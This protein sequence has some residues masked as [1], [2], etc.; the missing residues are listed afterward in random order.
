MPRTRDP[1]THGDVDNDALTT[2][3]TTDRST[4]GLPSD[5]GVRG[6]QDAHLPPLEFDYSGGVMVHRG[7]DANEQAPPGSPHVIRAR[8]D[9]PH[10]FDLPHEATHRRY[11]PPFTVSIQ[12]TAAGLTVLAPTKP[13]LHY[14]KLVSALLTGDAAGTVKFAQGPDSGAGIS[15]TA[16][17]TDITGLVPIAT[18]SGFVLPPAPLETPWLFT[19]PGLALCIFSVTA[20]VSGFVTLAYSPY[21]S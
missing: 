1:L 13:G 9:A 15:A 17:A 18:N 2:A 3:Q 11:E 14:V 16:A 21:D 12:Q 10:M 8:V 20:K 19:T 5:E 7:T 6:Q 4:W